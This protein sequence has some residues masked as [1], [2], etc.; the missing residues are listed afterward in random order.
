M[1]LSKYIK[2]ESVELN[3]SAIHFANYNP[4]K[5]SDESR[6]TL[7][8]G[9][10][11]FGLVG[12]IV[13]NKRTGLTVVSGHQRLSVMDELQKFPEN[14]YRIRVDVIDVDEK[15]EKELNIL[16]N[17]PNAQGSWDY[18]ALARLV[19][20]IDYQDAGLTAADLNMIGCDFLLQTEEESSIADALEDMMA[21]VTEQKEAEKAAK[22]AEFFANVHVDDVVEGKVERVT[23]FG[24]FVSVNGFDCLARISDISW[25]EIESVTDVLEIGKTYQFKVLKLDP[26]NK[27]AAI[28]YKQLQPHPWDLVGDKYVEGDVIHG[29]VV[30]IVPFGAF[31]EVEKGI[32]GLVHVSQISHEFL[33]NPTTALTIGQEIDAKILRLN[34][35]ERKMTLSIKA[36]LPRPEREDKKDDEK[37]GKKSVK[38]TIDPDEMTSWT[39]DNEGGASIADLM[40]NN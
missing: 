11:K 9:I 36:L 3:R 38:T 15:Q 6:K 14:D 32:D 29:K 7:K 28:G 39:D 1:E 10:K 13:V 12:G 40:K 24:A 23:G 35:E 4:R 25:G 19:P 26:A 8:R 18:D 27:K 5:L 22:E 37:G 20:D 34:P 33:E 17:N 16:M 2:S 21:P 30:R 31:V